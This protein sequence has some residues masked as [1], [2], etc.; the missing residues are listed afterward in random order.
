MKGVGRSWLGAN[1][2]AVLVLAVAISGCANQAPRYYGACGVGGAA[3]GLLAG[4]GAGVGIAY[5]NKSHPTGDNAG[6][7]AGLGAGIGAVIGLVAGHELCDPLV[8][9]PPPAPLPMATPMPMAAQVTAPPAAPP[10]KTRIV[11]RGVHFDFNKFNIRPDDEPVLDEAVESLKEH[12]DVT[13]NVNGYCDAVGG[14]EYNL[15]LS[16]ERAAAVVQYLSE[17]GVAAARLV[18][19]GYGKT[20][21]VASNDTAEGRAQNRRDE[22][23]PTD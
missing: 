21:F 18:A 19:H 20:N 23:V 13:V 1:L 12:P 9:P 11:L 7:A 15:R 14:V 10:E 8:P 6:A 2:I 16:R 3:I 4:A 5:N 17:H 22:L